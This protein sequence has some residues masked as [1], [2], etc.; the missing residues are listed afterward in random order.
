MDV[1]PSVLPP[2]WGAHLRGVASARQ[3]D[4][5][6][7][8]KRCPTCNRTYTDDALRFCL[9][10][11][12][13]LMSDSESA[14]ASGDP[15]RTMLLPE[16]PQTGP[17]PT[18]AFTAE[19]FGTDS[20]RQ[21]QAPA[22][23]GPP[24]YNQNPPSLGQGPASHG[25]GRSVAPPPTMVSSQNAAA[26]SWPAPPF[27]TP[28]APAEAKSRK[29]LWIGLAVVFV[30][31]LGGIVLTAA[32]LGVR[33]F[34]RTTTAEPNS[35]GPAVNVNSAN[36]S[37]P[38][39][40]NGKTSNTPVTTSEPAL[41]DDFTTVKWWTGSDKY[42][43]ASYVNGE[44]HMKANPG[45]YVVQYAP[46]DDYS[47]N[48]V[49]SVRVTTHLVSS[50]PPESGYGLAVRARSEGGKPQCYALLLEPGN[51]VPYKVVM[52]SGGASKDLVQARSSSAI[53]GGT[54]PNQLEVRIKGSQ[55]TFYAN[56][57]LLTSVTDATLSQGRVGFYT[58]GGEE[59]A[60]DN[61]EIYK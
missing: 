39:N 55:Y 59:I 30:L 11:G 49:S 34:P 24:S 17:A 21:G 31:V 12:S 18:Q 32:V 43:T 56:G 52:I 4:S 36:T 54:A 16:T 23:Q 10:D 20:Y 33:Y 14:S 42:L 13:A 37:G 7:P 48:G 27:Q 38:A 5:L 47:T 61:L 15:S 19:T 2:L 53:H 25:Q 3:R 8:M 45:S 28:A 57:Q 26:S 29:G 60:F 50:A 35:N 1:T 58:S 22:S 44:Y 51:P 46:S 9:E 6:T 41:R 40:T